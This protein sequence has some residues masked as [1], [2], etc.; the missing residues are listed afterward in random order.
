MQNLASIQKE[1]CR[2][3]ITN[4]QDLSPFIPDGCTLLL[5]M[6]GK[7]VISTNTRK[8]TFCKGDLL[9][10]FSDILFT[11]LKVSATFSAE[12]IYLSQVLM[13]EIF[14]KMT[15]AEFWACVYNYPV[16]HLLAE[17]YSIVQG[18]FM[19]MQWALKNCNDTCQKTILQNCAYN[20]FLGIDTEYKS[21][22]PSLVQNIRKD[23]AWMLFGKFMSFLIKHGCE[24]RDVKFYADR[25]CI[26]TDYLYKVC[27]KVEQR[28][29][30]EIIDTFIITEIKRYLNNTNLSIADLA[31][32]FHFEDSSYLCR[33][34][35]RMTGYSI[36]GYRNRT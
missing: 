16:C 25:L 20:L 11:P 15:S 10:L 19:Q 17:Q 23:R 28:T 13:E 29:P 33:F 9:L 35:R 31:V 12:Y 6:E 26:T 1:N 2:T 4:L 34:F 3:G 7:A 36:S 14:Y 24:R 30:K 8:R 22:L 5:C 18:L 21:A 32:C 27:N